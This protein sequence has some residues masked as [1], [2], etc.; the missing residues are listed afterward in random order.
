MALLTRDRILEVA[1]ETVER[2][3]YEQLSLRRLAG[4]LEVTAPALYDHVDS[5]GALLRLVADEGF[6]ELVSATSSDAGT[7][8]RRVRERALA[9][10][11][12]AR[13]HAE[14]FRLM[15][16]Y[17][18]DAVDIDVDNVLPGAS[19]AW[20]VAVTD[21]RT[22]IADGDIADRDPLQVAM[23]LWVSMHGVATI[24]TR[25]PAVAE[26]VAAHVIDTLL[27]GLHPDAAGE[28]RTHHP[29]RGNGPTRPPTS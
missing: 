12:F 14:L 17:R 6:A 15:F 29:D 2:D 20:H 16:M 18:P 27:A 4:A 19:H 13:Q 24:A 1:R 22:A 10:V 26:S 28:P 7:P 8:I 21:V 9:Y 5:K 23:T 3:G 25:A 11:R